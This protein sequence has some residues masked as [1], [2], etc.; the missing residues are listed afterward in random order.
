MKTANKRTTTKP[1]VLASTPLAA[2]VRAAYQAE[3]ERLALKL[4]PRF[5]SGELRGY[6]D[7]DFEPFRRIENACAAHF[8]LKVTET[9][10]G[11]DGDTTTA[12]LVLA[13]SPLLA[14]HLWGD[15]C[16]HIANLAESVAAWDLLFLARARGWS[17]PMKGE[18]TFDSLV[19]A[20]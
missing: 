14:D 9:K 7:E 6:I 10:T 13:A 3:L 20:A 4:R 15:G 1:S 11:Y 19:K 8:G 2:L 18:C 12:A 17:K 16:W 5:E